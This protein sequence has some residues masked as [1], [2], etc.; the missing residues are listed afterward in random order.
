MSRLHSFIGVL[1]FLSMLL[2]GCQEKN[3]LNEGIFEIIESDSGKVQSQKLHPIVERMNALKIPGVSIAIIDDFKI[4]NLIALGESDSLN[5]VT[6]NTIFQAASVSKYVTAIIVHQLISQG[7]L[8][9]DTDVNQYLKSWKVPK[10][11]FNQD[12]PITLRLLL[13][14]QS[15]LP[16]TNFDFDK[17]QGVPTLAQILNADSP[18]INEPAIPIAIP[19]SRWSYSNIGYAL[20]QQILEDV[21][22]KSFQQI[23]KETLF[24]PLQ[25][26]SSTFQYP[27][28]P[29]FEN[30]EAKPHDKF[31]QLKPP[32]LELPAKAQ[33]GLL[34]TPR[35]LGKLTIEIMK[36]YHNDSKIFSKET[37]LRL[38]HNE[39]KLPFT[40]YNQKAY[41]GLGVLLIGENKNIAFLHNGYNSPGSVC[42]VIGFPEV[43]K[44]AVIAANSA[45][46]E[47]LYL[48]IIVTLA[49]N[50]N[51]PNGQFFKQ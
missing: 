51:W 20:I 43:G 37:A 2:L 49:H 22:A 17:T 10:N 34:T 23:A 46:G 28:P 44:G 12:T 27:L 45:N 7:L 18:A 42:I 15:G 38:I 3:V 32:Q 1:T 31:G 16:S 47:Q 21:T 9:L 50:L 19:G 40:F 30:T 13:S 11:D 24:V 8:D 26:S 14:H 39:R 33:G 5:S 41:M 4:N 25:M 48:E 6:K 35:D 29:N 36:A